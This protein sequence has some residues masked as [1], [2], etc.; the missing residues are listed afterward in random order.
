VPPARTDPLSDE[1]A[2]LRAEVADLHREVAALRARLDDLA[3]AL[4]DDT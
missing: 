2:G 4:G 3:H 1:V